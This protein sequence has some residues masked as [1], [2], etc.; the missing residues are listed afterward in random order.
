M[1]PP[2]RTSRE[3]HEEFRAKVMARLVQE[4][5]DVYAPPINEPGIHCVVRVDPKGGRDAVHVDVRVHGR[6]KGVK[7]PATFAALR[8]ECPNSRLYFIFYSE[9]ADTYWVMP[10]LDLVE[11][12]SR[13]KTGDNAGTYTIV[14]ARRSRATGK[15]TPN[16]RF[17][18]YRGNFDLLREAPE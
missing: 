3:K 12:A 6:A 2:D 17:A 7:C 15:M 11:G 9:E 18:A 4:G 13:N 1:A 10:S 14:L 16:E 5:F 8:I